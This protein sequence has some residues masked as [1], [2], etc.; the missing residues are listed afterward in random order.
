MTADTV[1]DLE[2][3]FATVEYSDFREPG[4]SSSSWR[5]A[6]EV[7]EKVCPPVYPIYTA[8]RI[9]TSHF[10]QDEVK[11][12]CLTSVLRFPSVRVALSRFCCAVSPETPSE[13]YLVSAELLKERLG[14]DVC[15][16]VL[17]LLPG[18]RRMRRIV[19]D[20]VLASVGKALHRRAEIG[21]H[22]GREL[23]ELGSAAGMLLGGMR[24]LALGLLFAAQP[25][26]FGV[27]KRHLDREQI[28]FD[29]GYEIDE[30]GFSHPQIMALL[31]QILG[32][33]HQ[34]AVALFM[35]LC[36]ISLNP[37]KELWASRFRTVSLWLEDLYAGESPA[38]RISLRGFTIAESDLQK[39]GQSVMN[40][41][42]SRPS[43]LWLEGSYDAGLDGEHNS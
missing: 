26:D 15:A 14:F 13:P 37:A 32:F 30:W 2:G 36:P 1:T 8:V 25:R 20:G 40:S 11:F 23:P 42:K 38:N 35:G 19:P 43:E 31:T 21:Y 18:Y 16:V 27:Y 7:A 39:L 6:K 17:G 9:L 28:P 29:V 3:E 10:I 34:P 12:K 33:G 22:L 5:S 4:F 41:M 24:D